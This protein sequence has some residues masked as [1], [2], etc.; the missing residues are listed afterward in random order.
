MAIQYPYPQTD[1]AVGKMRK[2]GQQYAMDIQRRGQ[3]DLSGGPG[4]A[5]AE[6]LA[7]AS[8]MLSARG[9]PV[10]GGA[11]VEG[12]T[13]PNVGDQIAAHKEQISNAYQQVQEGSMTPAAL[14]KLLKQLGWSGDPGDGSKGFSAT[15]PSGEAHQF[16]NQEE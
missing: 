8:K 12:I 2:R 10:V 9:G 11:R 15:D 13:G 6:Q 16:G 5:E 1:W 14:K 7:G 3:P 4:I